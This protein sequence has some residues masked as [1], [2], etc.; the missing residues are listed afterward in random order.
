M[1]GLPAAIRGLVLDHLAFKDVLSATTTDSGGRAA[2]SFLSYVSLVNGHVMLQP[3]MVNKLDKCE[4]LI[5]RLDHAEQM[6]Q[7][8]WAFQSMRHLRA[9]TI[10]FVSGANLNR[11]SFRKSCADLARSAE[12]S[13]FREFN[14]FY[15]RDDCGENLDSESLTALLVPVLLRLP[16]DCALATALSFDW[17]PL[18]VFSDILRRGA[19][20]NAEIRHSC[21]RRWRPTFFCPLESAC[22]YERIEV[23]RMLLEAGARAPVAQRYDPFMLALQRDDERSSLDVVRLLYDSGFTSTFRDK[24][25]YNLLHYFSFPETYH[26]PNSCALGIAKLICDRQ[27]ELLTQVSVHGFTP[28]A[29]FIDRQSAIRPNDPSAALATLIRDLGKLLARGEAKRKANAMQKFV[30]PRH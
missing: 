29:I 15:R 20:I 23:I 18:S 14:I 19:A 28:L 26:L 16:P 2:L 25:N 13:R 17:V 4:L 1:R 11:I 24:Q 3:R 8:T 6:G 9:V 30:P 27:P 22:R 7:L 12:L 5:V 21:R 10:S